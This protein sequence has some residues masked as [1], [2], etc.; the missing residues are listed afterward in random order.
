MKT[1]LVLREADEFSRI[2]AADGNAVINCPVITTEP[3]DDLS[4]LD[5]ALSQTGGFDGIF[6]TSEAATQILVSR[7]ESLLKRFGGT[8]YVLGQ[9]SF[10]ILK[11]IGPK[12]VFDADRQNAADMLDGIG[13]AELA[14]KRFLF[15]CGEQS[16]RTIPDRLAG[17]AEVEEAVVYRTVQVLIPVDTK[18]EIRGLLKKDAIS[19]ACF[20]SPSGVRSFAGQIG[21]DGLRSTAFGAIGSTTAAALRDLNLNVS[22]V[23]KRPIGEVFAADIQQYLSAEE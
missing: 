14:G 16:M 17:V 1:V 21:F 3:L 7:C 8:I 2:L 5:N 22:V 10:D 19:I 11:G 9:R 20:F 4:V 15:V 6:V 12:I 23:A 18:D 13:N